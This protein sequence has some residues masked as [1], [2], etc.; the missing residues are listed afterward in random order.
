V[1]ACAT[2]VHVPA[3]RVSSVVAAAAQLLNFDGYQVIYFAGDEVVL[4]E[5]LLKG[6]FQL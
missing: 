2:R 4:D 6:Q 5:A 1:A 3:G